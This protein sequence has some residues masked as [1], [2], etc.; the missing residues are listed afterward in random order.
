M[1]AEDCSAGFAHAI[2]HAKE[3]HGQ[4]ADPF[5]PL[6]Q[7]GIIGGAKDSAA[8]ETAPAKAGSPQAAGAAATA[9]VLKL[10]K[11]LQD[12]LAAVNKET[13]ELDLF[14]KTWVKRDMAMAAMAQL[15]KAATAMAKA[16]NDLNV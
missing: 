6:V 5:K 7:A 1:T 11:D 8:P 3:Y 9:D 4:T 10:S 14:K 15:E 13:E 16:L 12:V 2:V